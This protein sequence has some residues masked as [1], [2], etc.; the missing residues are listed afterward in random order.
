M[1]KQKLAGNQPTNQSTNQSDITV[2]IPPKIK[3]KNETLFSHMVI[4][5]GCTF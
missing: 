3:T 5:I 2:N 4:I 1:L